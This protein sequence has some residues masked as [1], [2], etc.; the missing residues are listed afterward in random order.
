MAEDNEKKVIQGISLG[1]KT[2]G[3]PPVPFFFLKITLA[4]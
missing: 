2:T 4:I 1:I 3:I